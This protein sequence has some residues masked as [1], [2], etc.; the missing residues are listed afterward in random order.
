MIHWVLCLK[1]IA[2]LSSGNQVSESEVDFKC[3]EV[4]AL[5]AVNACK[6]H[7]EL[8]DRCR[9]TDLKRVA[10]SDDKGRK[11]VWDTRGV[12][13]TVDTDPLHKAWGY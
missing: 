3:Y 10:F 11:Q 12:I 5:E 2:T 6:A 13:I 7:I 8:G 9:Y 4:Q 1:F